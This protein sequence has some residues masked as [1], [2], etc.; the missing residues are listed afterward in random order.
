VSRIPPEVDAYLSTTGGSIRIPRG[1][2]IAHAKV[3]KARDLSRWAT[4]EMSQA[5][6]EKAW[7]K[8]FGPIPWDKVSMIF[9]HTTGAVLCELR[10]DPE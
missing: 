10:V 6:A 7:I 9:V 5:L 8:K 1:S 3:H 4:Q 2:K